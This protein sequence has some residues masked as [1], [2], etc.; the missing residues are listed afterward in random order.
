MRARAFPQLTQFLGGYFHEDWRAEFPD[1]PAAVHSFVTATSRAGLMRTRAE[2]WRLLDST[3]GESGLRHFVAS[4]LGSAFEPGPEFG[5][6]RTWLKSLERRLG[7]A[8]A[9]A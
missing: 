2:L 9:A 3:R 5:S 8:A 1:E 6:M 4:D 7:R